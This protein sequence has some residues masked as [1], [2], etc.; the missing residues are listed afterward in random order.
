MTT[1]CRAANL[2][3]LLH[4]PPIHKALP[5]FMKKYS[6]LA[7]ED[8][9]GARMDAIVRSA[10]VTGDTPQ[11][12]QGARPRMIILKTAMLDAL[13]QRLTAAGR[14]VQQLEQHAIVCMHIAVAGV[15]YKPRA[16]AAGDSNIMF[17][18][19]EVRKAAAGSIRDI[20]THQRA[21]DGDTIQE[22]F[23]V[24]DRLLELS[25]EEVHLDPFRKFRAGGC[26]FYS[27][28]APNAYL[29]RPAEVLCHTANTSMDGLVVD[30]R[31]KGSFSKAC[32]HVKP[33]DRVS[34]TLHCNQFRRSN[35]I[36]RLSFYV[37]LMRS[38]D[39]RWRT[40]GGSW[41]HGRI[42]WRL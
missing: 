17:V 22:T 27:E 25:P 26:L 8:R 5:T 28:Y 23:L 7:G 42:N 2:H 36:G 32:V 30:G 34:Y 9:R 14:D 18:H 1:T 41:V 11:G 39:Y 40:K 31:G 38:P 10:L 19:P 20:F 35:D 33:L 29:I 37:S 24:V 4:T 15:L 21:Q 3:A 6:D 13:A 16:R 12:H